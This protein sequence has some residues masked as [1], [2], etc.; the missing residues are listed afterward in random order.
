MSFF[1][2]TFVFLAH[3]FTGSTVV[4]E[5]VCKKRFGFVCRISLSFIPL[6]AK[7]IRFKTNKANKK[8]VQLVHIFF[9]LSR[10]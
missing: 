4:K 1:Y 2:V 7:T 3:A 9:L 10:R 6:L 5:E 8:K